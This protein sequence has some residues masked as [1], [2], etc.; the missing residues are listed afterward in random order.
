[1]PSLGR[2][3]SFSLVFYV[4]VARVLSHGTAHMRLFAAVKSNIAKPR[5]KA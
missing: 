4:G 3:I 1:M 5:R 2:K